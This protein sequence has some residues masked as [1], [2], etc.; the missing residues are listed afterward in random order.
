MVNALPISP[1]F[2]LCSSFLESLS[3][4]LRRIDIFIPA[5]QNKNTMVKKLTPA[6]KSNIIAGLSSQKARNVAY[7]NGFISMKFDGRRLRN[8]VLM[9]HNPTIANWRRKKKEVYYDERLKR[10]DILPLLV[11]ET[12]EKYV[13]QR[14]GLRTQ[15]E[16]HKAAVAVEK[17]FIGDACSRKYRKKCTH[18]GRC[19][20]KH[21]QRLQAIWLRENDLITG[22]PRR[23]K[24][25]K[26]RK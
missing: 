7:R 10:Q 2:P 26:R 25:L 24:I 6:E 18:T 14:Y 22:R 1:N 3:E 20:R 15:S 21:E 8:R 19:W 12:V 16:A 23:K 4:L 11:H 5:R 17:K 9:R 13:A